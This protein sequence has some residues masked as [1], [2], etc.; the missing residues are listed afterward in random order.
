MVFNR[1]ELD[2]MWGAWAPAILAVAAVLVVSGLMMAWGLL[3]T[4]YC[5]PVWLIG[6]YADR[7]VDLPGSWRL[8]GATLMPGALFLSAAI[9][10]YGL[11]LLDLIHLI[12]AGALHLL[13]GW[14]YVVVSPFY[15]PKHA[16]A[17]GPANP[18]SQADHPEG[19]QGET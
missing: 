14:I 17:G 8:A 9:F 19:A 13:L 5:L 16:K 12:V 6:F 10:F 2:P 18:F 3:A 15:L 11:A 7:T 4:A 1:Q